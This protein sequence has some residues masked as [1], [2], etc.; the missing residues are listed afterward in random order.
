M[1]RPPYGTLKSALYNFFVLLPS[2]STLP[3]FIYAFPFSNSALGTVLAIEAQ[4]EKN[5]IAQ[6]SEKSVF[7]AVMQGNK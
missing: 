7:G 3:V 4:E 1:D 6:N 5:D 2:P